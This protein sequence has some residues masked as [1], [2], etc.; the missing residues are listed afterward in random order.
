MQPVAE[1]SAAPDERI[2]KVLMIARVGAEVL[3][4]GE[5]AHTYD[6]WAQG[7]GDRGE[8]PRRPEEINDGAVARLAD[9]NVGM[10]FEMILSVEIMVLILE[11]LF[12]DSKDAGTLG[13]STSSFHASSLGGVVSSLDGH[14]HNELDPAPAISH[15]ICSR[16]SSPSSV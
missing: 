1:N 4:E 3:W 8:E 2:L 11:V 6:A 12:V 5:E 7:P 14:V 16:N 9:F 13:V 15:P 10:V